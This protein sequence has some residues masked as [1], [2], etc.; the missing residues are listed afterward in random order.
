MNSSVVSRRRFVI[1]EVL[2]AANMKFRAYWDIAPCRH[3]EVDLRLKGTYCLQG[4]DAVRN[5]ETSVH[6]NVTIR[7]YIPEDSKLKKKK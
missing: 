1:F 5:P 2:T 7:H 4:D 6:F 3:V